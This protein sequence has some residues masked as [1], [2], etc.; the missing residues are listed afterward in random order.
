MSL[1]MS[2]RKKCQLPK[3]LT[4]Y[5]DSRSYSTYTAANLDTTIDYK[6]SIL[7]YLMHEIKDQGIAYLKPLNSACFTG[8]ISGYSVL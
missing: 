2:V 7:A 5:P 4:D 6:T 1:K 8:S 3:I